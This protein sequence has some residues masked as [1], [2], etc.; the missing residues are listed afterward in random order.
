MQQISINKLIKNKS[1]TCPKNISL[2]LE[3]NTVVFNISVRYYALNILCSVISVCMCQ[4]DHL[5]GKEQEIIC[6]LYYVM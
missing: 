3:C 4:V 1:T 6:V 2:Y 5:I